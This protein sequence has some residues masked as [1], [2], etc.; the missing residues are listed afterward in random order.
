MLKKED[1]EKIARFCKSGD[2]LFMSPFIVSGCNI[3][4]YGY[5]VYAGFSGNRGELCGPDWVYKRRDV[6][7]ILSM[8]GTNNERN[9]RWNHDKSFIIGHH[10]SAIND[11]NFA[12]VR[13]KRDL[14]ESYRSELTNRYFV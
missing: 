9:E 14:R 1:L 11:G 3:Y 2:Y 10:V 12:N 5:R 8:L 6:K 4:L 13:E 7:K